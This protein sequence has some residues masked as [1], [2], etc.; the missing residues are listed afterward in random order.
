[1]T[2]EDQ[3]YKILGYSADII[4]LVTAATRMEDDKAIK[5][6]YEKL[7][8]IVPT[9]TLRLLSKMDNSMLDELNVEIDKAKTMINDVISD[10]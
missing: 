10:E 4:N 1:M 3:R 6:M 8:E 7:D 5:I 2:I 9:F